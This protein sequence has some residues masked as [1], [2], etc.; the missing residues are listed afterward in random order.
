[1]SIFGKLISPPDVEKAVVAHINVW[2]DTYLYEIERQAGLKKRS[3]TRP[4]TPES[5]RGAADFTVY[6]GDELPMVLVIANPAG[7]EPERDAA[8]GYTQTYEIQVA[9]VMFTENEDEARVSAGYYG[10]AIQGFMVQRGDLGGIASSTVMVA[11]PHTSMPDPDERRLMLCTAT[12]HSHITP[13]VVDDAGPDAPTPSDSSAYGGTPQAP[14]GNWPT[15]ST[16]GLGITAETI[17]S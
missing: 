10:G 17:S 4:P 2:L 11:A 3:L 6:E 9:A 8:A 14:F 13:I 5:I 7:E 15:V 16:T 12:F 1:M